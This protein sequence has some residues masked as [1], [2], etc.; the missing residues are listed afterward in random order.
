[1]ARLFLAS[2]LPERSRVAFFTTIIRAARGS[3]WG[4]SLGVSPGPELPLARSTPRLAPAY[5]S[6][7]YPLSPR[8]RVGVRAPWLWAQAPHP[9]PIPVG[10][11]TKP[12]ALDRNPPSVNCP[13][14]RGCL[15]SPASR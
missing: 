4:P 13:P 10:E 14:S 7:F 8:E 15:L 5:R 9:S 6:P 2:T 11:G 3:C 1:M 12:E